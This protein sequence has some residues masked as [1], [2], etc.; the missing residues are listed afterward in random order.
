MLNPSDSIFEATDINGEYKP[1]HGNAVLCE[2]VAG[3]ALDQNTVRPF[4]ITVRCQGHAKDSLAVAVPVILDDRHY[5]RGGVVTGCSSQG[6][7]ISMPQLPA[8]R[9]HDQSSMWTS[10]RLATDAQN[11]SS[12]VSST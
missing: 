10:G 1:G 9:L 3:V 8:L 5:C 2:V 11:I 7:E 4:P 12:E 6:R